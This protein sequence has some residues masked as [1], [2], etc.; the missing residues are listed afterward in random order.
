MTGFISIFRRE[1]VHYFKNTTRIGNT[2]IS[3]ILIVLLFTYIYKNEGASIEGVSSF[4][5]VI[6]G[7]LSVI[8]FNSALEFSADFAYDKM[9]GYMKE[10]LIS[11]L[12]RK[13]IVLAKMSAD[14][15]KSYVEAGVM[16]LF[17]LTVG[18]RYPAPVFFTQLLTVTIAGCFGA[19]F[20]LFFATKVRNYRNYNAI[21]SFAGLPIML[22]SGAYLPLNLI[23]EWL[24]IICYC[25]PLTYLC[26]FSKYVTFLSE[27]ISLSKMYEQNLVVSYL[28]PGYGLLIA[29]CITVALVIVTILTF[30]KNLK[31]NV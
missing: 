22:L 19:S 18:V 12:P 26:N 29:G 5:M 10:F 1:M 13:T 25:N 2:I 8:A 20:G 27:G 28:H 14:V 11:P 17:S 16:M 7:V 23:P 3:P 24:R 31:K 30:D 9:T 21:V 6:S 15:V 4:T